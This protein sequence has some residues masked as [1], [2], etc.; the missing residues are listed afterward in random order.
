MFFLCQPQV[1]RFSSTFFFHPAGDNE[2]KLRYTVLESSSCLVV[3]AS[4]LVGLMKH[5]LKSL[6]GIKK[7]ALCLGQQEPIEEETEADYETRL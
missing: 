4:T 5:Q 3:V 2:Q 7:S 6:A 1:F